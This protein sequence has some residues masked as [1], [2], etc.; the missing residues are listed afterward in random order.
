MAFKHSVIN[1]IH[2]ADKTLQCIRDDFLVS[3]PIFDETLKK[4]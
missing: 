1:V 2:G 3:I 4:T